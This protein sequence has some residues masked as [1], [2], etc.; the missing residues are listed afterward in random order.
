MKNTFLFF[1]S[2]SL[3]TLTFCQKATN[4]KE[5]LGIS[6]GRS[7][8]GTGD[9]NGF[10]FNSEY[11]KQFRRKLSWSAT[12]GGTLHDGSRDLFFTAPNGNNVDGSIRY[13]TG[14]IQSTIGINYNIIQKSHGELFLRINSLFR[15]QSTS[16]YDIVTILY[17]PITGLPIPVVYFENMSPARTFA[18]GGTGQVGYNYTMANRIVL[19]LFGDFQVDSNGDVLSQIGLAIG[20]RF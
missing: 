6:V 18:V 1:I 13:T 2:I 14:G 9:I 12:F 15:Y 7:K 5:F 4:F 10:A 8:H 16:Y 3:S 17:P 19:R 20:K 11:S